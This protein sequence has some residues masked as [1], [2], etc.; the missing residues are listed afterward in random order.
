MPSK[1]RAVLLGVLLLFLPVAAWATGPLISFTVPAGSMDFNGTLLQTLGSTVNTGPPSLTGSELNMQ[2]LIDYPFG[3]E[4]AG[5]TADTV[6]FLDSGTDI[7]ITYDDGQG[8]PPE[9]LLIFEVGD[10]ILS[11]N[12][13]GS[14]LGVGSVDP[15]TP[16]GTV[17]LIGGTMAGDFSSVGYIQ[18]FMTDPNPS[19]A[20]AVDELVY[21]TPW[22][23]QANVQIQF[24]P[25]PGT[26]LLVSSGLAGLAAAGGRARRR[27]S[28]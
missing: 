5:F 2:L 7:T 8:G 11:G 19:D 21:D 25:E 3:Q 20:F 27:R 16:R 1:L 9:E 26:L 15:L 23:A 22:T 18:I 28:A 10:P 14:S 24:L 13:Q 6:Q 12:P 4:F 17:N